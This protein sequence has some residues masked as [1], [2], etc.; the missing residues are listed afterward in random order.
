MS[1]PVISD[2]VPR[3]R[4]NGIGWSVASIA[5]AYC[6]AILVSL[7]LEDPVFRVVIRPEPSTVLLWVCSAV[8]ALEIPLF[9]LAWRRSRSSASFHVSQRVLLSIWILFAIMTVVE[10]WLNVG[11]I[12]GWRPTLFPLA[13]SALFP[14]LWVFGMNPPEAPPAGADPCLDPPA[15]V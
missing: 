10:G 12:E 13:F 3:Q 9:F 14:V 4:M 5:L 1:A 8:V 7:V 6:A 2:A 15:G 11:R